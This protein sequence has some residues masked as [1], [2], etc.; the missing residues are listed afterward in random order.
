[1]AIVGAIEGDQ[2]EVGAQ[3]IRILLEQQGWRVYYLGA[4]VP[5]EEFAEIQRAQAASLVCISFSPR[6]ALPDLQRA[7]RVLEEFYR[8]GHP[9]A[10][11]LGG[12]LSG[13]PEEEISGGPFR[14]TSISRS[15]QEFLD[16]VQI[17][18]EHSGQEE[19]R[20]VA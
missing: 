5:V 14:A 2:H 4:D 1:V 20:R 15:A 13:F 19:S 7:I 9:Y 16:W 6:N 11:A 8:P 3:A 17:L 18:P 12:S 10:L